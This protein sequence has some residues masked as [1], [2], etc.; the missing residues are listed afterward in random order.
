[1]ATRLP[2]QIIELDPNVES[3]N[4]RVAFEGT[5]EPERELVS[6]FIGPPRL[7]TEYRK[8]HTLQVVD[9]QADKGIMWVGAPD[10]AVKLRKKGT[11]TGLS[12]IEWRVNNTYDRRHK[13][14]IAAVLAYEIVLEAFQIRDFSGPNGQAAELSFSILHQV[15][16]QNPEGD[17][18]EQLQ[19]ILPIRFVPAEARLRCAWKDAPN[20][21]LWSNHQNRHHLGDLYLSNDPVI[22]FATSIDQLRIQLSCKEADCTFEWD[23]DEAAASHEGELRFGSSNR[24]L[25]ITNLAVRE[26]LRIPFFLVNIQPKIPE[27]LNVI[28]AVRYPEIKPLTQKKEFVIDHL[29]KVP[30]NIVIKN[31]RESSEWISDKTFSNDIRF[32]GEVELL[33]DSPVNSDAFFE[34]A[35]R[36]IGDN[37]MGN[38]LY[39]GRPNSDNVELNEEYG[40]HLRIVDL[41]PR[42]QV[43][44]PIFARF[45]QLLPTELLESVFKFTVSV[46]EGDDK[47]F[48]FSVDQKKLE[49]ALQFSI[50]NTRKG[51]YKGPDAPIEYH[52][53]RQVGILN[54]KE[55]SSTVLANFRIGNQ[56]NDPLGPG[57]VLVGNFYLSI[58]G[59]PQEELPDWLQV[60]LQT[61]FNLSKF[62]ASNLLTQDPILIRDG[63]APVRLQLNFANNAPIDYEVFR[64]VLYFEFTYVEIDNNAEQ[65]TDT[66]AA[67]NLLNRA[68]KRE[69]SELNLELIRQRDEFYTAIDLGTSA[70]VVANFHADADLNYEYLNLQSILR[71][72]LGRK[73]KE[74]SMPEAKTDFLASNVILREGNQLFAADYPDNL[75]QLSPPIGEFYESNYAIPNIKM[76]L[77]FDTVR[78]ID[79]GME[80]LEY[81]DKSN[82]LRRP[83]ETDPLRIDK[84]VADLFH[85]LIRHFILTKGAS[86]ESLNAK[87]KIILT[88]PNTF[89][90]LHISKLRDTLQEA[91]TYYSGVELDE[92]LFLSESD[93]V[94]FQYLDKWVPVN[95][96][97]VENKQAIERGERS[98][99]I[100]V[101]DIGAGTLDLTYLKKSKSFR[102]DGRAIEKIDVLGR[103][104]K[105]TA[106][107][108]IDFVIANIV[109][110]LVKTQYAKEG[111]LGRFAFDFHNP[112]VDMYRKQILKYWV[113]NEVKPRLGKL[114]DK[115]NPEPDTTILVHIEKGNMDLIFTKNLMIS[116][117]EIIQHAHFQEMLRELSTDLFDHFFKLFPQA[118]DYRMSQVDTLI[119]SGRTSQMGLLRQTVSEA[120]QTHRDNQVHQVDMN[121]LAGSEATNSFLKGV[122]ARGALRYGVHYRNQ[123]LTTVRI[124]DTKLYN[125]FGIVY[126]DLYRDGQ[127]MQFVEILGPQDEPRR[128][129][130]PDE[131]RFDSRT[132][133]VD[134]HQAREI[135]FVQTYLTD[136][137]DFRDEFRRN[138]IISDYTNILKTYL[139]ERHF[140]TLDRLAF[141]LTLSSHQGM[142]LTI[143]NGS[144]PDDVLMVESSDNFMGGYNGRSLAYRRSMWPAIN[145]Q[146]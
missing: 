58:Q 146:Q 20:I 8:K 60:S 66:T 32:I 11:V 124:E 3:V 57:G 71:R 68:G 137:D 86:S 18:Q 145:V 16:G 94:A 85:S 72:Y 92:I 96:D 99:Y 9:V 78:D 48:A 52:L 44:L 95:E 51:D 7:S 80:Q 59:F 106:G 23:L 93:A 136:K 131:T 142:I 53:L 105:N 73:Y 90:A 21:I 65:Y 25:I 13:N 22:N 83:S 31:F 112:E 128:T 64:L 98:E 33:N 14:K 130:N 74:E 6:Q 63:E 143:A 76:I 138:H 47:S 50:P 135:F 12:K 5:L 61:E 100:L 120:L 30:A 104:G 101:Y 38:Y 79:E 24:E 109:F 129:R 113:K 117:V 89:T 103:M 88:V 49:T 15:E 2:E 116:L 127:P 87:Q 39:F 77:G 144:V 1:M 27:K 133:F 62:A 17:R 140:R 35:V 26:R 75:T 4:A 123:A 36:L 111:P 119:F 54:R 110:D 34:G 81:R 141:K 70:I 67:G 115:Q 132:V 19:F 41:E 10:N 114:T 91:F 97:R 126:G 37:R 28:V 43:Q 84:V 55:N 125:R 134:I 121:R 139:K 122:V 107:N 102:P 69:R 40:D 29:P 45:D 118:E 108:Y 82:T 42:Q 56:G 46:Q